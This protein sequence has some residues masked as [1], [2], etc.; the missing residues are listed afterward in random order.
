MI[1]R[2]TWDYVWMTTAQTVA[3]RSLCSRAK[4]GCV[5]V[6]KDQR[7]EAASYNG[8]PPA[9]EHN[10]EPCTSWCDRGRT[11]E[12]ADGYDNCP[13]NHAEA[14]AIGRSNWSALD[15]ATLYVTGSVC[16]TCAKL[17]MSTGISR[18]VYHE[19]GSDAHRRPEE[20][21][22]FLEDHGVV[23]DKWLPC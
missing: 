1:G 4:M 16:K 17:I 20:T 22:K 6:T 11:G 19:T 15:G 14:N 8:P 12:T 5:I 7:I 2:P 9:F 21:I 10:N 18:V 23:V 13:A 3:R